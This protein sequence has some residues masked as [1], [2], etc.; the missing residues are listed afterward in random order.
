MSNLWQ[1]EKDG[2]S[3]DRHYKVARRVVV[4]GNQ[5]KWIN[6]NISVLVNEN[7]SDNNHKNEDDCSLL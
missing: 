4:S 7:I 5:Q 6:D 1:I 2:V 3:N